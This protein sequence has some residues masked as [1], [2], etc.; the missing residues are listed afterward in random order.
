MSLSIKLLYRLL[1]W[2]STVGLAAVFLFFMLDDR[3]TH[4]TRW[5][6]Q[7]AWKAMVQQEHLKNLE[8]Q[9]TQQAMLLAKLIAADEHVIKLIRHA[10]QVHIAEESSGTGTQTS[11]LREQLQQ[12]MSHYWDNALARGGRQ[13]NI[14]FAPDAVAFLRMQRPDKFGDVFHQLRPIISNPMRDGV[15]TSGLDV[16]RQGSGFRAVLPIYR[17][18]EADNNKGD[19]VA[20][21]E[22]GLMP[23][24]F[25]SSS[26]HN[27]HMAMLLRK[28]ATDPLLW[29]NIRQE[30][31]QLNPTI[32]DD[33]RIEGTTDP[34]LHT[35]WNQR[36]IK[37]DKK[38][39][40]LH[41]NGK[42]YVCSWLTLAHYSHQPND[43]VVAA[44]VWQ[45]V[46][47]T[48]QGYLAAQEHVILKWVTAL[49]ASLLLMFGFIRLNRRFVKV[50]VREHSA[51][52]QAEHI[53]SE[54]A[55]Q[56]L[57]LALR[58]SDSGFWE[59]DIIN[60]TASFSPE[61]RTLCGLPPS[62]PNSQDLDEWMSRVHPADKR[63]SYSDMIRHIK[64]ETPM[65]ENEYRI[66]IHDGTY[67]W[68]LT[69]GKVVKWTPAG[70]AALM[71]G[72]YSDITER[73]NTELHSIR[74]QAALHALNEIASLPS[75]DS[76]EQLRRG[77][78]LGARYLAVSCAV[79]S[80]IKNQEYKIRVQHS[81]N[82]EL[83]D[84]DIF[85]LNQTYC[86][87]TM[88]A[89][90]IVANDAIAPGEFTSEL[91]NDTV[92]LETYIGVPLWVQGRIYGTLCFFSRKSR[93]HEYDSLDKDFVRLLARWIS[94][95][96]ERWQQDSE[97]KI[98]LQRFQKLSERLPG[99]LY[100][101][102]LRPDGSS[103]YP[104]ASSGIKNIYN[105]TPEDVRDN[106]EIVFELL[107]PDDRAWVSQTISS[108]A[109]K[110]TPWVA[111][112]RV[113]NPVRG[114]IWTHTQA[115]PE[116]LNDGSVLW[117][118]YVSD[119]TSL[120]QTELELAATNSLRQA[121][122]DA[123]NLSIISTDVNGMIK[124]FNRG[125]EE[126]LGYFAEE[127]IDKATPECLHLEKEVVAR[128]KKLSLE[129]GYQIAPGFDAFVAKAREGGEDENEWTYIRKD[130]SQLPVMLSVSAL[131]DADGEVTG[132]LGIARDISEIKRI[133]TLKAEFIST[134]S[135]ELRTPL[136]AISAALGLLTNNMLGDFS[137]KATTVI[138]VAHNNA[139]RLILLV[140]DLLDMEKLVAGKMTFDLRQHDLKSVIQNALEANA[141][142]AEKYS[143]SYVLDPDS[144]DVILNT[145]ALRL[146]QVL[147]NFL[148]NAAKFSPANSEVRIKI[149][150]HFGRVRV[151]VKDEGAGVPDEFRARIFKKFSQADSSD[152][153][154]KGGTGLGLSICKEMIEHMGGKVGFESTPGQGACFYFELPCEDRTPK[155]P[156]SLEEDSQ[157][158]A[159]IL[160]VEDEDYMA[161]LI[162][163]TLA[164]TDY[165]LDCVNSGRA[166]LEYLELRDYLAIT[167]DLQLPD[168]SGVEVIQQLRQLEAMRG[169][170]RPMPIIVI[171]GTEPDAIKKLSPSENDAAVV[172]LKKPLRHGQLVAELNTLLMSSQG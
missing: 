168:M 126:M 84:G 149:E 172:W 137:E 157:I 119:I 65:Y 161:Q 72:V 145:D 49:A 55:R 12:A 91:Q 82:H 2:V 140:N 127:L 63:I 115:I 70:K 136:T 34:K 109:A 11:A 166:A 81:P 121:I 31:N 144:D 92:R 80:E 104:Y 148:S 13:L 73:K 170:Q 87:F 111:T 154:K 38:P 155:L 18:D 94:A 151:S 169:A 116:R 159:R 117:H 141:S 162:M 135:H 51:A 7:L 10:Q 24:E 134:V 105:I 125:A 9:L 93:Q 6:E 95:V 112:V 152:A 41:S 76:D 131:R 35:W 42:T 99:F 14:Y 25:R 83:T 85:Q 39:Q 32:V 21:I 46:T 156:A 62:S 57:A 132:Y 3:R 66:R 128:A 102:Q 54:Q 123:A 30:L 1:P 107:H 78:A 129:L 86:C 19:V 120:K 74:Q 22:V 44:L 164:D 101:Y 138:R 110:L 52:L 45:D 15:A 88:E 20:V 146:Q 142:Y 143:V 36:L 56:H 139:Q 53:A 150:R 89:K 147:A 153:R 37:N 5:Q 4:E 98:I 79:I 47:S 167:L 16:G 100:Q 17:T 158:S 124:T 23:L 96:V 106:A 67:K 68:I 163:A 114:L 77:L 133:D 43:A 90:D 75:L 8:E 33:W 118:G 171:S 26:E 64:G 28:S 122:F 108:S 29:D 60:E 58:S 40:L 27:L 97:K 50:L 61:W 69:R 103:F 165:Q 113:N 71:L 130:G 48:Y 59:W 160:I